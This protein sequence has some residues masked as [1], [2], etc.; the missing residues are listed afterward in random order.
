M[1]VI[2]LKEIHDLEFTVADLFDTYIMSQ[3]GRTECRY[4]STRRGKEPLVDG[5]L[6]TDKWANFCVEV[7]GNYEF[8]DQTNRRHHV[9]KIKDFRG[10]ILFF[11]IS[12]CLFF[13]CLIAPYLLIVF[14]FFADHRTI[15]KTLQ[16]L[17][18]E[19]HVDI[20]RSQAC[21]D[22]LTLL[23]YVPSY[24]GKFKRKKKEAGEPSKEAETSKKGRNKQK[25]GSR[26]GNEP[27]V[28]F[29]TFRKP[30]S[31][32]FRDSQGNVLSGID[33]PLQ[34]IVPEFP[35][36]M[37]RRN[38]VRMNLRDNVSAWVSESNPV[39]PREKRTKVTHDFFP[40]KPPTPRPLEKE[41]TEATAG[42]AKVVQKSI[43][44]AGHA[45]AQE[46][47]PSFALAE[48]RLVTVEDSVK[49]EHGL[50]VIMLQGLSQCFKVLRCQRTWRRCLR[51]YNR[52][53]STQ[54][55]IWCRFVRAPFLLLLLL[56]FFS[57]CRT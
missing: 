43:G 11:F 20:L 7:S 24:K 19:K 42:G 23:G 14:P 6:D 21:R 51:T 44:S 49:A 55:L 40:A 27:R 8:G 28:K 45:V 3:H 9:P 13:V 10:L 50:A 4:L 38:T 39:K 12:S 36:E 41:R 35:D 54:V 46:F 34:T 16:S 5:L 26:K 53:L 48:G 2:A 33:V 25:V 30:A 15:T 37:S 56:L 32:W 31:F 29:L 18:T 57:S 47:A 1:A 17:S 22:A 52:T